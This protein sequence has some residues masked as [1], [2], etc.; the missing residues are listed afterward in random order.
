[1]IGDPNGQAICNMS[2]Y[3]VEKDTDRS[4]YADG[5]NNNGYDGNSQHVI[6]VHKVDGVEDQPVFVQF[7]AHDG[8]PI[9]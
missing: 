6:A 7:E 2:I 8:T 5:Y 1:L 9:P 3:V 4:W